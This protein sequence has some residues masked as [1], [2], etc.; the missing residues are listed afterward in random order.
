[1]IFASL[2]AEAPIARAVNCGCNMDIV[3]QQKVIA[4]STISM[5]RFYHIG[6]DRR[7][8]GAGGTMTSTKMFLMCRRPNAP[9][10]AGQ[11]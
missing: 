9:D 5:G 6:I 4:V 3:V 2:M 10:I 1:V 7:T 11:R 8:S